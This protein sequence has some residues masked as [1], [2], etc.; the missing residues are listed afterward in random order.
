MAIQY[1]ATY[2]WLIS[3]T[4]KHLWRAFFFLFFD[5]VVNRW[6]AYLIFSQPFFAGNSLRRTFRGSRLGDAVGAELGSIG[7]A[8]RSF[9]FNAD[10]SWA[11]RELLFCRTFFIFASAF[12]GT[13][14]AE[15]RDSLWSVCE[16]PYRALSSAV[17]CVV[18]WRELLGESVQ[19]L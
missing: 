14:L 18:L 13:A 15:W 17:G 7:S 19:P 4:G 9:V 12:M 3:L 10:I 8:C 11:Q 16:L 2:I 1:N 5:L 6:S